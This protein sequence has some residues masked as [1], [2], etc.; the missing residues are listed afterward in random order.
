MAPKSSDR[1]P[2]SLA[3]WVY[4]STLAAASAAPPNWVSSS[5]R[6]MVCAPA[7]S[8]DSTRAAIC[9]FCC[10]VNCTPARPRAVTPLIGSF[11]A[12]PTCTDA[13]VRSVPRRVDRFRMATCAL[14]NC[15]PVTFVKVSR[16]AVTSL[17]IWSSSYRL[18]RCRP[19]A[20]SSSC[21]TLRP[22]APPVDW[23]AASTCAIA[24]ALSTAFFVAIAPK[25]AM[26]AVRPMDKVLPRSF[27]LPAVSRSRFVAPSRALSSSLVLAPNMIFKIASLAIF[28]V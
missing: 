18:M 8:P 28:P 10:A 5:C 17:R 14:S 13:L 1:L 15:V 6:I 24:L 20:I 27:I 22:A 12:L 2:T 25:A 23:T 3:S 26:G 4:G 9:S 21:A 19:A 16:L 7:T 11:S